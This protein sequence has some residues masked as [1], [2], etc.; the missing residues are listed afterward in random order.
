VDSPVDLRSQFVKQALD[1]RYSVA[2]L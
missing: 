1:G 2:E